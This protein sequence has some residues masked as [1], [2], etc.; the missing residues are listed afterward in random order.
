MPWI[1]ENWVVLLLVGGMI[2]MHLVGHIHGHGGHGK[3][4][5]KQNEK[6]DDADDSDRDR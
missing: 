4:T 2:A 6:G 5:P 1:I 3:K